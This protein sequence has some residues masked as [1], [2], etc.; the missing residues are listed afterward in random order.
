MTPA[1]VAGPAQA[2]SRW[3]P[4]DLH[5]AAELPAGLPVHRSTE[6]LGLSS[7]RLKRLLGRP[8]GRRPGRHGRC[9]HPLKRRS[10]RAGPTCC[11]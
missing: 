6:E 7:L 3:S 8:S 1:V 5:L 11:S 9:R 4:E 2:A 10:P